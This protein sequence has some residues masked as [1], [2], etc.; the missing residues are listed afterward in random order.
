MEAYNNEW[1]SYVINST[2]ATT[3]QKHLYN[4]ILTFSWWMDIVHTELKNQELNLLKST[5]LNM[6]LK[7]VSY[8]DSY[9]K[10]FTQ[11]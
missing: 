10:I 3:I 7:S 4:L 5:S 11:G 8:S 9:K 1:D 2:T 6:L